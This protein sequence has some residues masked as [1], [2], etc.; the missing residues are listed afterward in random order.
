MTF[1]P[2]KCIVL[3]AREHGLESLKKLIELKNYKIIAIFTHRLNP[4]SYDPQ[5]GERSDFKDFENISKLYKIPFFT[6]DDKSEK[7]QLENF[8][9]ENE[10]DFLI[11]ISWRYLISPQ[12]FEKAKIGSINLHRGDLPKYAGA[13][14]IKRALENKESNI[15]I[16]AHH[17]IQNYDEGE[18]ICKI[19][20]PTNH[21]QDKTLD[22]NVERLKKEITP[23]F[24][25]LT[26]K[27][28]EILLN[29]Y[30]K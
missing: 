14:P 25:Q 11:S 30:E 29:T 19:T 22:E 17:I 27:S 9:K 12:V 1:N 3:V 2:H 15:S 18:I 13:E 28:L 5:R 8:S 26:I 6:I 21:E 20:Y 4:K 7:N 24:P 16:C 10:F 23:Y